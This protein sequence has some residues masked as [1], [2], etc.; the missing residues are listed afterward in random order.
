MCVCVCVCA[1]VHVDRCTHYAKHCNTFGL[2]GYSSD[3]SQNRAACDTLQYV[4][5]PMGA[6]STNCWGSATRIAPVLQHTATHCN[7]LQQHT[8]T[9]CIILQRTATHSLGTVGRLG[10]V[11]AHSLSHSLVHCNSTLHHSNS[12][13]QRTATHDNALQHTTT[14][15][16]TRQHNAIHSTGAAGSLGRALATHTSS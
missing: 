16:N 6:N 9:C 4:C 13:L 5:T 14:H 15:C 7:T 10:R 2:S 12:V 3:E 8:A 1:S 11:L